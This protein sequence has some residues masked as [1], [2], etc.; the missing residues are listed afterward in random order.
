MSS[1][2]SQRP[3]AAPQGIE[4]TDDKFLGGRVRL[5]QPAQGFRAG[6]DSVM[7]A[8]AVAAVPRQ[9]VCDLGVGA[10]TASLCLAARVAGLHITG[11]EIDR[12]LAELAQANAA[13]NAHA[14]SF[15]VVIADVLKRPRALERQSF[16]HVI[17]NPP[18]HNVEGGTRAPQP[19]K[20]R[21]TSAMPRE[22]IDWLR[23]ARALARPKGWVTAIVPPEQLALALQALSPDGQGVELIPLWPKQ[24]APAKRLIIRTRTNSKTPLR[25]LPGLVLHDAAGGISPAADAVLRQ[26][27]PLIT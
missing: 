2:A 27:E 8:A 6:L 21:A 5:W 15:D 23:F 16:H 22:L 7:L 25:L 18:F 20:A 4:V 24:G 19:G 13:R 3:L 1:N 12:N 17:T 11:V 14:A 10:G 9:R 26:G